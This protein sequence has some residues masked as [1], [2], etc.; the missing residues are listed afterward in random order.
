MQ[1]KSYLFAVAVLT[2]VVACSSDSDTAGPSSS[3]AGASGAFAGGGGNAGSQ[4]GSVSAGN[5]GAGGTSGASGGGGA[6]GSLGGPGGD[7]GIA[8]KFP[9]TTSRIAILADQFPTMTDLQLK[10]A[11]HHFVGTEKQVIDVTRKLRAETPGFLV[12][13]YHLSM[14]Q[15]APTTSFI[16]DGKNWSNDYPTVDTHEPWFWHNVKNERVAS[17]SDGKLLMNVSNTEFQK[18]WADSLVAQVRAG[19]YDA[20]FFDSA[21]PALLQGEASAG[22]PRLAGTAVKDTSFAELGNQTFIKAWESWTAAL[23]ATLAREGI[24][25]MPNTGAFITSW[26]NTNYGLTAGIF[27]EGFADPSFAPSDWKASTNELLSL[28]RA[29]KIMI[30]QNY[31]ANADDVK[32]R[33][34]YLGNYLLV[35]GKATYLDYFAGGPLEWYPEWDLDLGSPLLTASTVD[36]L[37]KNGVFRRDFQKGFVLVNPSSVAVDVALGGTFKRVVPQGG[38]AIA[39]GGT[40]SGTLSNTDMTTITVAGTSAE[41]L[42]N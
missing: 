25:L 7:A 33:L 14:W 36:D 20:I 24:P 21:S 15:S 29:G 40:A 34:Y 13:H 35:K 26:D 38:G 9:D 4:D 42:L 22:D 39:S 30:L 27:S 18:Y 32:K 11:A 1:S 3:A 23:D 6:A 8:A 37:M 12:L 31:L 5:G 2:Q 16:V 19:E 17:T 41:I 28:S 10:F